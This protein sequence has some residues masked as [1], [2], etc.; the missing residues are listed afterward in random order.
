[1]KKLPPTI[2]FAICLED[3]WV[4]SVRKIGNMWPSWLHNTHRGS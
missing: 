1:L 3:H 2:S 4:A